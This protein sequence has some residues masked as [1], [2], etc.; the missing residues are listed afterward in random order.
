MNVRGFGAVVAA[1]AVGGALTIVAP[2]SAKATPQFA[3]QTGKPCG[4]CHQNP[5]GSGPLKAF[6]AAFKANGFKLPAKK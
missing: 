2:P 3:A 6:G 5:A 1:L 4:T